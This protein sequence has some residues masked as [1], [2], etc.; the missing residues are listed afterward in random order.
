MRE[1]EQLSNN[2]GRM[3]KDYRRRTGL[4]GSELA[5]RINVSQQQISRYE[6]GVN[7]ISFDKLIILF[8]A[9]EMSSRDID[10]FF[11]KMKYLFDSS[12]YKNSKIE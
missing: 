3:L 7:N 8:N 6:N 2:I 12:V 10:V 5:K 4:T 11:E 1:S 9:L